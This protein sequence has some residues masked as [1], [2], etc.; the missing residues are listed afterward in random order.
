MGQRQSR[1]ALSSVRVAAPSRGDKRS[2]GQPAR[3]HRTEAEVRLAAEGWNGA[4]PGECSRTVLRTESLPSRGSLSRN[5]PGQL[6]TTDWEEGTGFLQVPMTLTRRALGQAEAPPPPRPGPAAH[7]AGGG[8]P[9]S[10]LADP[11]PLAAFPKKPRPDPLRAVPVPSKHHRTD[12]PSCPRVLTPSSGLPQGQGSVTLSSLL[13][14]L[15]P[16]P[17][18]PPHSLGQNREGGDGST[19][20]ALPNKHEHVRPCRPRRAV[21]SMKEPY[22]SWWLTGPGEACTGPLLSLCGI[23]KPVPEKLVTWSHL[24]TC[25]CPSLPLL[26]SWKGGAQCG[27]IPR[28]SAPMLWPLRSQPHVPASNPTYAGPWG[29]LTPDGPEALG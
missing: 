26:D 9:L 23:Y 20:R 16:F 19:G 3:L 14:A 29:P 15:R 17:R 18:L 13:P 11:V 24:P 21:D 8:G 22:L 25:L 6:P 28:P 1:G 2:C 10:V 5:I 4:A 12:T 27:S 7:P